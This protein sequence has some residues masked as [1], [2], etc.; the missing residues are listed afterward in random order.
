MPSFL[1]ALLHFALCKGID[2]C[3]ITPQVVERVKRKATIYGQDI[4]EQDGLQSMSFKVEPA[5]VAAL[6]KTWIM[7][8]TKQVQ[9]AYLLQRL[10]T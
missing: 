10:D 8:L 2:H 3:V 5:T 9:V 4:S 6:Y 7:P 1:V